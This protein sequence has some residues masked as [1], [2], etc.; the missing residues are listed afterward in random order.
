MNADRFLDLS[1]GS[2]QMNAVESLQ[3]RSTVTPI[4]ADKMISARHLGAGLLSALCAASP[5]A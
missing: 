1:M 4:L 3:T 2:A 5:S